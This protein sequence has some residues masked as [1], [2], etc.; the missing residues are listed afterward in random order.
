LFIGA[1]D[2]V[3]K[4]KKIL[5]SVEDVRRGGSAEF[6]SVS[7]FK[8]FYGSPFAYWAP[9]SILSIIASSKPAESVGVIARQGL[10]TCDNFRFLRLAHEVSEGSEWVPL[11]KG[12][13]YQPFW[14]EVPL[15]VNWRCNGHEVKAFIESQHGQWSRVIQSTNLYGKPGTTYSER[16]ASSLSLRVLPRGSIFDKVGPFVGAIDEAQSVRASLV[17][18]GLSYSTPYRFLVETAV[19]LRDGTTSGSAARHYL[20]SMVQRL[21][22]PKLSDEQMDTVEN[23]TRAAIE[24]SRALAATAYNSLYWHEPD[25]WSQIESIESLAETY[26]LRWCEAHR[27]IYMAAQEL[28]KLGKVAVGVTDDA[29]YQALEAVAGRCPFNYSNQINSSPEDVCALVE[30][31]P[32]QLI[33]KLGELGD[34]HSA[35]VKKGYWGDRA[36][37]LVSHLLRVHPMAI[38]NC[39]SGCNVSSQWLEK[40]GWNVIMISLGFAFGHVQRELFFQDS[41]SALPIDLFSKPEVASRI[42]F[43]GAQ[44]ILVDDDGHEDDLIHRI[45][46]IV[47]HY[48]GSDGVNE[49]TRVLDQQSGGRSLRALISDNLFERHIADFSDYRRKAP[50]YWQIATQSARYSVWLYIHAFSKDTFFRI[51]N[52]YAAPKLAHE[53]RRLESLSGELRDNATASQRRELTVQQGFVQ[54]LRAFIDEIKIVASLWNPHLD[55]GVIINFAPLWRLVPQNKSWQKEL[56]STWDGLCEGKYDWAHLAMH[57]WPERVV[58]KCATDRSLAISHGL[59]EVF[60]CVDSDGKSIPN[61][62]PTKP[63]DQLIRERAS[64][65]VKG[66][67]LNLLNAPAVGGAKKSAKRGKSNG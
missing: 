60:W 12:G 59:E 58:P 57:L 46:E 20:P 1:I 61:K 3:S 27:R 47:F 64:P 15:R 44:G 51:L 26:K 4:D 8:V 25:D 45:S 50:I 30:T 35:I 10:A 40:T 28:E 13:E 66:A 14:A 21:P 31:P 11:T 38:L 18:I 17:L 33:S 54:E 41:K 34:S 22:W 39:Y 67:L 49:L 56:K 65:A 43:Q 52:D 42:R 37:E 6:C 2:T 55:D 48:F 53:E 24:T 29:S 9:S 32:D 16:T 23:E 62:T 63:L 36:I 5:K 7:D 19:G